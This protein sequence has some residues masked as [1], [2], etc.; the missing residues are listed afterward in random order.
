V[1]AAVLL[2]ENV[3]ILQDMLMEVYESKNFSDLV[4]KLSHVI[5]GKRY[6]KGKHFVSF[7]FNFLRVFEVIVCNVKRHMTRNQSTRQEITRE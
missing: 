2:A 7:E 5:N 4:P 3:P 6:V 1:F